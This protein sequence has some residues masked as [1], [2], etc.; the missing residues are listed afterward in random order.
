[1]HTVG[2]KS[3]QLPFTASMTY[4]TQKK[5]HVTEGYLGLDHFFLPVSQH[6]VPEL[7]VER[8]S[9]RQEACSQEHVAH[10]ALD[11]RLERLA[12]LGPADLLP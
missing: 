11:L 9:I 6:E 12:G 1:M 4:K 7:L 10:Q 2:I 5:T 8:S 3:F